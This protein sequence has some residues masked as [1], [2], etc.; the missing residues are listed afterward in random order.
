MES[1]IKGCGAANEAASPLT[2]YL[3][4]EPWEWKNP[5]WDVFGTYEISFLLTCDKVKWSKLVIMNYLNG[6][7]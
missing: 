1:T 7:F 6:L 4:F 3:G 2:R 5:W